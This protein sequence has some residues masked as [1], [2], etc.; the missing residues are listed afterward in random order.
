MGSKRKHKKHARIS[1]GSEGLDPASEATLTIEQAIQSW[2]QLEREGAPET[3]ALELLDEAELADD[4]KERQR[5]VQESLRIHPDSPGAYMFLAQECDN[6]EAALPHCLRAVEIA[7]KG[8]RD[9]GIDLSEDYALTDEAGA[10]LYLR[11]RKLLAECL[12]A[13]G[14]TE[15][16]LGHFV[17]MI[18]LDEHDNVLARHPLALAMQASGRHDLLKQLLKRYNWDR[19]GM[20]LFS[21][22][23]LE[24][25]QKGDC[26]ASQKSLKRAITKNPQIAELLA[27]PDAEPFDGTEAYPF[28]SDYFEAALYCTDF[29][30]DW[31][32]T[33]GAI[34]WLAKH[35]H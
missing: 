23:L 27:D 25:R 7:E 21:K 10:L 1:L 35:Q 12:I 15:E 26:W 5:L 24:Y 30:D 9:A 18:R 31:A 28:G 3:K 17:D 8:L 4:P 29:G 11:A 6:A 34:E 16:G 33:P 19:T 14:R 13:L 22:A 20:W 32:A 2:E